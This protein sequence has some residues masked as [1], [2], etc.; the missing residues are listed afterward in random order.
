MEKIT[1]DIIKLTA[2]DLVKQGKDWHFHILT[3][4]CQLNETKEYALILENN[5]DDQTWVY[6]SDKPQMDVGKYLVQI[7]HGKEVVGE[8][9]NQPEVGQPLAENIETEESGNVSEQVQ[10]ILQKAKQLNSQG[11]FWHHHMLFPAC[12]F[13][14]HPGKFTIMFEDQETGE[15]I[16]SV[17][18][19]EPKSDLK[20]IET[21]FY[22]QKK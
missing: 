17:T 14:P 5:S 6:H 16:E 11:K 1:I 10:K 9:Q 21:L 8:K 19:Q 22:A 20:L 7:L 18:N 4:E 3:P 2:Q 13:N 12:K 15:V